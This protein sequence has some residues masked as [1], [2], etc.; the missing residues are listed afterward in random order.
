MLKSFLENIISLQIKSIGCANINKI[1]NNDGTYLFNFFYDYI[2]NNLNKK[3]TQNSVIVNKNIINFD[4][5]KIL[6]RITSILST[7]IHNSNLFNKKLI[8]VTFN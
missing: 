1:I 4:N 2:K 7:T 6:E 8:D 3:L 5:F